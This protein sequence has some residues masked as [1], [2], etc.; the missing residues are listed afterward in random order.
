MADKFEHQ[1]PGL[2]SP[3]IDAFAVT[4]SN[5]N[6]LPQVTRALYVGGAGSV[7]VE[8]VSGSEAT[9]EAMQAGIMYPLRVRKVFSTGTS[10]Q[11][12]VGIY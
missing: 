12:L 9:F 2:T 8:L 5:G 1:T 3:G 7:R 11:S 10:A 4:P 6:D